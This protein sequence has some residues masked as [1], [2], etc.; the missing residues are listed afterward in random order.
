MATDLAI[1]IVLSATDNGAKNVINGV[2]SSLT[3][4]PGLTGSV[5]AAS[6][7]VA[8]MGVGLGVAAV[9]AAGNFQ[10]A[11]LQLVSHAG[12]A[13]DQVNTVTQSLI[14]M[15][16][17]VGQSSTV[18]AQALYP[19]LSS[20]SGIT[21]QSAKTQVSL[22]ELKDAAES[23][24][25]STTDVTSVT[26][27]ASAAF[28]AYNLGTNDTA[29]NIARM[30]GLFDEMNATVSAGNMQWDSYSRVIGKL[31]VAS[32]AAGVT[33]NE[34]NA[35]LADL[36]NS[37]YSAQLAST[38]LSNLF[39]Q[40]D[41]KTAS[42]AKNAQSLG[43]SFDEQKFKSMGL[44]QQ[45]EYINKAT[46]GNQTSILKLLNNNATA[47]KTFEALSGSL[48][49]YQGNLDSLNHSQGTTAQ[50]F[51]TASS[52]FNFAMQKLQASGQSF[53]IT[54]GIQ[55]LPIL[56]KV[57][58][59]VT[60]IVTS[61]GEWLV[62]SGALQN[63]IQFLVGTITNLVN[64]TVTVVSFFQH[65]QAAVTAL[66]AGVFAL[67]GAIVA[68][69]IPSLIA[70]AT[71]AWAAIVPLLPF[72]AIGAAVGLVIFGIV[73]AV[74]H[75]GQIT[76]WLSGVWSGFV[77]W[78]TGV[79]RGFSSWF[80]GVLASIGSFF[81]GLWRGMTTSAQGSWSSFTGWITSALRSIASFFNMIWSGILSFLQATWAF[82]VNAAK[83]AF[84]AL[85]LVIFGPTIAIAN[86]FIWLY[87]HNRYFQMLC[88]SIV[89]F[90]KSAIA[91]LVSAWS[92]TTAWLS[93]TWKGISST[94]SSV[95]SA[96]TSAISTAVTAT[97]SFLVSVWTAVSSWLS[98]IWRTTS[99]TATS[100]WSSIT[101]AIIGAT[102]AAW[103][104]LVSIW[105]TA[106][107]WLQAQWSRFAGFA[108]SAW[109]AVSAVFSS[110]WTNY[111][112]APLASAWDSISSWFSNLV[113]SA[114]QW[115]ANIISGIASGI[116][117]A[118]GSLGKAAQN[119]A[120]SVA[121]FLGFH[122]PAKM[123]P[124]AELDV[125]GPNLIKGFSAGMLKALPTLQTAVNVTARQLTPLAIP[126]TRS[127]G[128]PASSQGQ[129]ILVMNITVN[130]MVAGDKK[131]LADWLE[132][133]LSA[134]LRR[135]GVFT[136]STS[137]GK[138]VF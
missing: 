74:L 16:P 108:Q 106:T 15:G 103:S 69:M 38:Y 55:L 1:R 101:G 80:M 109:Q 8:A 124:G 117:N 43:L 68:A 49:N 36:T 93:S 91:W 78:L 113:S 87:Q 94:A 67:A 73:E 47:F 10:Q 60:P 135:S 88:D 126:T 120:A 136:T 95:W 122:S 75:W 30:N 70:M 119:A 37:G 129:T 132:K 82:L 64:T 54:V 63:G 9:N 23:V 115:G 112:S 65:N 123:G 99:G 28:N 22:T 56:T 134:R 5:V 128:T 48:K 25:G 7:A 3:G 17:A 51:A 61:L 131:A 62:K 4:T 35:A 40:L 53:L 127:S 42:L 79:W 100:V 11:V 116:T 41:L 57:V 138:A 114:T 21:D 110:I 45:I 26:N 85:L 59:A 31:S 44:G 29:L 83:I 66:E 71:A 20:L 104:W 77:S 105:T 14:Q 84:A 76:T 50:S 125:W 81:T 39:T 97:R 107:G 58:T 33:F 72:I 89:A 2:S 137:G 130:G 90:F 46:D 92:T 27:A 98:G 121:N 18:L 52:G 12:L 32:H 34:E 133:D 13:K 86:G 6:A 118:I 24:A 102:R 96:T 19:V 111:I